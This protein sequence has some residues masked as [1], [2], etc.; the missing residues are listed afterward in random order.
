MKRFL[1]ACLLALAAAEGFGAAYAADLP[2]LKAPP[3]FATPYNGAGMY[4][5]LEAGGGA[6][7]ADVSG[8][9]GVN[10]SSLVSAQGLAGVI[11]G[12]S[13]PMAN[14]QRYG[15]LEG[16][17]GMNNINGNSQGFSLSGPVTI[18]VLGGFG[19]PASQV[20]SF[21][22]TFGLSVPTL[23][24][25]PGGATLSDQNI[26][27]AGGV[28]ISDVSANFAG[29]S[30]HAW[31]FAPLLAVGIEGKVSTGGVIGARIEEVF[32][33]DGTCVGA[34]CRDAAMLT[35]AKGLYKF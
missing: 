34:I 27:L 25:L 33:M 28:D 18:Q 19:A 9:P 20:M 14:G 31:Q 8:I 11:V 17:F 7:T 10:P 30:N 35:R 5:G 23:P 22:P 2:P 16:D 12:Y 13:T 32:Q 1:I 21:L 26:Y 6:S 3:L 4:F 24:A 29:T 15:F